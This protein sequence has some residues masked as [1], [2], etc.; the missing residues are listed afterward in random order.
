MR[1]S[2]RVLTTIG[3]LGVV[4]S[5]MAMYVNLVLPNYTMSIAMALCL[6]LNMRTLFQG[7]SK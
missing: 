5:A 1:L 6:A 3:L 4:F 2:K 7:L